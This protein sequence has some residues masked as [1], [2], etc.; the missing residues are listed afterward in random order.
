[1]LCTQNLRLGCLDA[2]LWVVVLINQLNRIALGVHSAADLTSKH[3]L[4]ILLGV[5]LTNDQ[6]FWTNQLYTASPAG[7]VSQAQGFYP[8]FCDQPFWCVHKKHVTNKETW[9]WKSLNGAQK[10]FLSTL[11]TLKPEARSACLTHS[12]SLVTFILFSSRSGKCQTQST[13]WCSLGRAVLPRHPEKCWSGL[14]L[15]SE[16]THTTLSCLLL[17]EYLC[18]PPDLRLRPRF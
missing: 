16:H 4:W 7:L 5:A 18:T 11:S 1:M 12:S 14:E 3:H 2:D 17:K 9:A 10:H 15:N 13:R 6:C 8:R